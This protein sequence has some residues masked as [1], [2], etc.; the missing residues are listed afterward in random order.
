[1]TDQER[2]LA[3][4]ATGLSWRSIEIQLG[5][6]NTN[7]NRSWRLAGNGDHAGRPIAPTNPFAHQ[8]SLWKANAGGRSFK[9]IQAL[10]TANGIPCEKDEKSPWED[11]YEI[12]VR[13]ED[14]ERAENILFRPI[15]DCTL[16]AQAL[17]HVTDGTR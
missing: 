15:D 3:L 14:A 9:A 16:R 12:L 5:W 17:D 11:R 10:L 2:V 6:P 4:R 13:Q 1:M 8:I 7:G